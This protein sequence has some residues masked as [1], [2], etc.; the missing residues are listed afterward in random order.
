MKTY[1]QAFPIGEKTKL[2]IFTTEDT[3]WF[4]VIHLLDDSTLTFNFIDATVTPLVFDA[5]AGSDFALFENVKDVTTTGNA[6]LS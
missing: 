3:K 1:Y 5:L 6:L 4:T 2:G